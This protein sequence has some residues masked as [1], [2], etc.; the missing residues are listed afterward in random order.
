VLI[1]TVMLV[2]GD[3]TEATSAIILPETHPSNTHALSYL[4]P[5]VTRS[6]KGVIC[7]MR[8]GVRERAVV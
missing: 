5:H 8:R 1:V 3:R 2:R 7:L 6:R 4:V